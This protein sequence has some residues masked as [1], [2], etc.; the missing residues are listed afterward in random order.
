MKKI[1]IP[2]NE[3][4]IESLYSGEAVLLSG[5]LYT[6]RDAAHARLTA[7]IAKGEPLPF[8]LKDAVVYY[9]G[10]SPAKPGNPIGAAGPTTSYRM[11][12]YSKILIPLG[13]KI[14]IGKGQ[15][16]EEIRQLIVNHK[17]L[18]LTAT[19]GIAALMAKTVKSCELIAYPDL[20]PEAIYRLEV[21][22]F[23]AIVAYDCRGNDLFTTGL[24]KYR[25]TDS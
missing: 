22:D 12:A 6:A 5:T 7:A 10:P 25:K 16:T 20:G 11:D 1:T 21:E 15:R 4:T 3:A 17:G 19:G 8:E 14:M 18:Y 23:P 13:L 2:M 9:V 24:N